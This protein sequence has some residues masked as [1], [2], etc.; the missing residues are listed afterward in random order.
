MGRL[1]THDW[2]G[3]IREL[4]NLIE[5]SL[6][7]CDGRPITFTDLFPT[8]KAAPTAST[9]DDPTG[10]LEAVIISHIQKTLDACDGK[11]S[12]TGG[13]AE[14]LGLNPSTLRG[15]MRKYGMG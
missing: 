13:A 2:P 11:I 5:R 4:E 9:P 14:R 12:G 7:T 3:N 1:T 8:Q 10:T 6:I 15:K